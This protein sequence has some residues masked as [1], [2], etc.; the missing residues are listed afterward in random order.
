MTYKPDPEYWTLTDIDNFYK[1]FGKY[2]KSFFSDKKIQDL[3]K[4]RNWNEVFDIWEY[5]GLYLSEVLAFFLYSYAEIDFV[6]Y[7]RDPKDFSIVCW[8]D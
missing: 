4:E 6:P 7:L 5:D 2:L 1:N 3:V 8:E